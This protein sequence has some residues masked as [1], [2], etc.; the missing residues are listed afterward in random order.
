MNRTVYLTGPKG[1]ATLTIKYANECL[2]IV[3]NYDKSDGQ[4]CDIIKEDFSDPDVKLFCRYWREWHLNDM[5][6]GLPIQMDLLNTVYG[7]NRPQYEEQCETL[8]KAGLY[9]VNGY[10]YGHAW[11]RKEIPAYVIEWLANFRLNNENR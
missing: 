5:Q 2:S 3:G 1:I 11:L 4:I 7:D 8:K 6:A 9:E 10:K